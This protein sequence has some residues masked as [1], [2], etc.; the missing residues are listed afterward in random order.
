VQAGIGGGD[1][2]DGG[3]DSPNTDSAVVAQL[4][5]GDSIQRRILPEAYRLATP[6]SPHL[7]AR[8]DGVKIGERESERDRVTSIKKNISLLI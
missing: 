4:V 2:C 1:G 8:I 3:G 7:A 6:A 5:G